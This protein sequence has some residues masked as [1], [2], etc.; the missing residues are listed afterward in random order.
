MWPLRGRGI[1]LVM[2][3]NRSKGQSPHLRAQ[4]GLEVLLKL[5]AEADILVNN[6]EARHSRGN[7]LSDRALRRS[8]RAWSSFHIWLRSCRPLCKTGLFRF[9]CAG[10]E[11]LHDWFADRRI[12]ARRLLCRRLL[13]R[14]SC[15]YWC[16]PCTGGAAAQCDETTSLHSPSWATG[17][18]SQRLGK[19]NSYAS[20]AG[21][22]ATKDGYVQLSASSNALFLD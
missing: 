22:F 17:I 1:D 9:D 5:I 2:A 4:A 10:D 12:R 13:S 19:E 18:V 7:R 21:L 11:R 16:S 15:L 6:F 20:P 3:L 14:S 8:I